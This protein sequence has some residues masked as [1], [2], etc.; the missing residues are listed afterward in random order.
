MKTVAITGNTGQIGKCLTAEL[1][2]QGYQ[3]KGFTRTNGFDLNESEARQRAVEEIVSCDIFINL[4]TPNNQVEM[5]EL[6][7]QQWKGNKDK[8]IV[9][10][11]NLAQSL[12]SK[13]RKNVE[14]N[15]IKQQLTLKHYQ[16]FDIDPYPRIT[17]IRG[18][19]REF[20]KDFTEWSKFLITQLN[21]D[22]H[23][24]DVAFIKI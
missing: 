8:A 22:Y 2:N 4:A 7:W 1:I 23:I 19:K 21:L 3:V 24:I 12:F 6:V 11:G 20:E 15:N 16:L 14:Y 10:I 13:Y 5:L 17:L 9:N 18:G